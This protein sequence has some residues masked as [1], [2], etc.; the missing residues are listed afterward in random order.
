MPFRCDCIACFGVD[1]DS[2]DRLD[3]WVDTTVADQI[4]GRDIRDGLIVT[5]SMKFGRFR[6]RT[7]AYP[8][9]ARYS[10][11]IDVP[12]INAIDIHFL[13]G[14]ISPPNDTMIDSHTWKIECALLDAPSAMSVKME[15]R[16]MSEQDGYMCSKMAMQ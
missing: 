13:F 9:V 12:L 15:E 5:L 7:R 14:P 2:R 4:V 6:R 8:V 3:I 11:A 10:N 16:P 1:D